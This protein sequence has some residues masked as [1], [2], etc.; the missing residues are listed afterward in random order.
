VCIGLYG[1]GLPKRKSPKH[2]A[3][4]SG[5]AVINLPVKRWIYLWN[6]KF[7]CQTITGDWGEQRPACFR[8]MD[9]DKK[10]LGNPTTRP[11]LGMLIFPNLGKVWPYGG[12][13]WWCQTG[14]KW[15]ATGRL[16]KAIRYLLRFCL[17]FEFT[18]W[19]PQLSRKGCPYGGRLTAL[20]G[21]LTQGRGSCGTTYSATVW[22]RSSRGTYISP[23]M[24]V[25]GGMSGSRLSH[26]HAAH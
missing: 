7:T 18:F 14:R 2:W 9:E 22:V 23:R 15:V 16:Y 4:H 20:E 26:M 10:V 19:V 3:S 5:D 6:D 1:R 11:M 12:R 13:H 25:V 8:V 21:V 24:A 17:N